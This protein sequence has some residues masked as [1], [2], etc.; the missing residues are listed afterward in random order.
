[1]KQIIF[2]K[3]LIFL[4]IFPLVSTPVGA[5]N[6]TERKEKYGEEYGIIGNIPEVATKIKE[7]EADGWQEVDFS[8]VTGLKM[9]APCCE[10][11]L[12]FPSYLFKYKKPC[13]VG[14]EP[15]RL[16]GEQE[17]LLYVLF[18]VP[19]QPGLECQQCSLKK[20]YTIEN[21]YCGSSSTEIPK[22]ICSYPPET[23]QQR[24]EIKERV[25]EK[26]GIEIKDS[27]LCGVEVCGNNSPWSVAELSEMGELLGKLPNCFISSFEPPTISGLT[28]KGSPLDYFQ[29][30]CCKAKE[31]KVSKEMTGW[32]C[33]AYG[34][35]ENY[36]IFC[37]H[38]EVCLDTIT[39][40]GMIVHELTHAF[41]Q[42]GAIPRIFYKKPGGAYTNPIV[43]DWLRQTGWNLDGICV[44]VLGCP[45]A[46]LELP[47]DLPTEYAVKT[48]NPLE[49]MAESVRL[50]VTDPDRLIEISPRRYNFVKERIMCG[51]EYHE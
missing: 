19:Y 12:Q 44:P 20:V 31:G 10:P 30:Y 3:I 39:T 25:K 14:Y 47:P 35:P 23:E 11:K 42:Y 16:G 51:T 9:F 45:G 26:F 2:S 24:Q 6:S 15:S 43:I 40:G 8:S 5:Q 50:Y 33:A 29:G 13:P 22:D 48:R 32:V 4:L 18:D 21:D 27:N 34:Y 17:T 41:Q 36:V 49:D 37:G 46:N 28:G 7:I 38:G 1:M